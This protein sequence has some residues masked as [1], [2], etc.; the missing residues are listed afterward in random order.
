MHIDYD[1]LFNSV[2][3]FCKSFEPWYKK[4]LVCN[5]TVKHRNR[6]SQLKLSEI[7]TI[8]IAYHQSGMSCFK[9]F[10]Y[11]L[12]HNKRSLF[13]KLVHYERFVILIKKAFPVLVCLLNS[14]MGKVSQYLFID[15]TPMTVCHNRRERGHKVFKGMATKGHTS[16]GFF[17]G[18]SVSQMYKRRITCK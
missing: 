4:Q 7:T 8:I 2:D 12:L 17:F 9:Y 15:S 14:L 18:F 3:D 1:T 6:A 13:P 16:T 5:T 11:D 10:Y